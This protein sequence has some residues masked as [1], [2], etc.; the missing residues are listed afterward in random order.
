[1]KLK[2]LPSNK[3]KQIDNLLV[4]TVA[5]GFLPFTVVENSKFRDRV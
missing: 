2:E 1:M 4:G 5:E 3:V